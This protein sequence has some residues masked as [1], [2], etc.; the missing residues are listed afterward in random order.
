MKLLKSIFVFGVFCGILG[1]LAVGGAF[2]YFSQDLPDASE[3]KDVHLQTPMQ[4]FSQDGKLMSQFGQKR[5]IPLTIE[6][7]PQQ[8]KDAFL[9]I[10]DTRFYEHYGIDPVGLIRSFIMN[11]TTGGRGQGASTI[12][13]QLA[14][15]FFFTREKSYIRKIRE[16]ITAIRIEQMLSKDK[17]FELYLNKI[18]LGYSAFGVAAAAE[19]FFGKT[20]D[21]LTLSEI[22]IIA[23]LPKA[24]S[25]LNPIHSLKNATNRRNVVLGRM[26]AINM[27][28]QEEYEQAKG[29][30]IISRYHRPDIE[31]N[32]P[33][34]AEMVRQEMIER[35]GEE[36]AYTSGFKVYTTVDSK[37]QQAATEALV[38]NL[39]DYD[40]RHG[41]R[42]PLANPWLTKSKE[43]VENG[44]EAETVLSESIVTPSPMWSDEEFRKYL[45]E[46]RG[47]QKL[48][49]AI[50]TEVIEQSATIRLRTGDFGII[51]WPGMKWARRFIS[52]SR[53]G[54]AP[55][56][57][58]E[59][60]KPGDVIMVEQLDGHFYKLS[61]I[62][63]ASAAF[64]ALSPKDGAIQALVGGFSFSLSKFNRAAQAKRQLGSNIKPFIYSS[65]FANGFTLAS[66]IADSPINHWDRSAGVAWRPKN[67]PEE[68][69]GDTRL[70]RGLASSKNVMSVRLLREVGLQN[71][72]NHL[73]KFGFPL[74]EV[75]SNE[76]IALGA[77][78]FT[79]L[80]V[81]NGF[82]VIANGGY[83][84][85]P[86][87]IDRV[88]DEHGNRLTKSYPQIAC[89]E[90]EDPDSAYEVDT[91][92][93]SIISEQETD[94]FVM[95]P[96]YPVAPRQ[97]AERVISA[98]NAFLVTEAM[99]SAIWGGGN[100]ADGTAWRGTG[101]RAKEFNRRDLAGKTGTTNDSRDAWFSG[102]NPN[103]IAT[104]WIG[105]D[106]HSKK[107]GR[108]S[109]NNN[110]AAGQT[111]GGEYGSN[112]AQPAWIK[113]MRVALKDIPKGRFSV[114]DN[115]VSVRIDR[116]TGLL[117]HR[118]DSSSRFEYFVA[119]SEPTQ[120]IE[121][122]G[123]PVDPFNDIA[124]LQEEE[125][126][127]F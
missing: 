120:Y 54:T 61:Q 62:P 46:F 101:W 96:N 91:D 7:I 11:I 103:L 8:M 39:K 98:T 60:M 22:A 73:S 82:A 17:I 92:D 42:G 51:Q 4:V 38:Q 107:L 36:A 26:L 118:T 45:K 127:L 56:T 53:Q 119:G 12:T 29:E 74:N 106:D 109:W 2:V 95:C 57:A 69:L 3:L 116:K 44:R 50:V 93:L 32:A 15:N 125:Q 9:A 89:A 34:V 52:D 20:V 88:E 104:S 110:L 68:Y 58:S 55:K 122:V 41:Y 14:R 23:G 85:S 27:I 126:E 86:Y 113:F 63:N 123:Q 1:L 80:Q 24:P 28:S 77:A 70:R 71:V 79:P 100:R 37:L 112:A 18:E 97:Q 31:M 35:Y 48:E 83:K 6:Q 5:R 47:Y 75:P 33:Y 19:V 64:V 10:E 124:P 114:P 105:F 87:L 25:K 66:L 111:V 49:P 72:R 30:E 99:S 40:Q 16:I 67:A 13:M 115:I 81:A 108:T 65:A 90:C 76:S 43:K 102:F 94:N 117:T 121:D 78:S 84:V 59:I 21:E